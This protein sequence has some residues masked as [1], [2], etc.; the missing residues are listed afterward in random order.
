[1]E[2][3]GAYLIMM[4]KVFRLCDVEMAKS[5]GFLYYVTIPTHQCI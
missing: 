2:G 1:M 5:E 4:L 3:D